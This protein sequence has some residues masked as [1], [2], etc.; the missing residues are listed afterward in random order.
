M[1]ARL[2]PTSGLSTSFLRLFQSTKKILFFGNLEARSS[3]FID[4]TAP[5][6]IMKPRVE[7]YPIGE[8]RKAATFTPLHV[9]LHMAPWPRLHVMMLLLPA[10]SLCNDVRIVCCYGG[11]KGKICQKVH[12]G[13]AV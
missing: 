6:E 1:L 7:K 11:P 2:A 8:G 5:T 10:T 13:S 4:S 3:F 12:G 9:K